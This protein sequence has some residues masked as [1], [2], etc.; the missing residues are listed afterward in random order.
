M[1]TA[2]RRGCQKLAAD[3]PDAARKLLTEKPALCQA[4]L[5]AESMFGML[6]TGVGAVGAPPAAAELPVG[7]AAGV[8]GGGHAEFGGP[9]AAPPSVPVVAAAAARAPGGA[10]TA[11]A[12]L[13]GDDE[14]AATLRRLH[15]MSAEEA[16]A[17]PPEQRESV[18]QL[19]GQMDAALRLSDD[20]VNDL[21]AEQRQVVLQLRR[22][23]RDVRRRG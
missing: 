10:T 15:V 14:A 13:G 18:A 11:A 20:Q 22:Q 1:L 3:D 9:R 2:R 6:R 12:V 8:G 4:M 21:S 17:L 7:A 16:T 19:R 23:L 5:Q